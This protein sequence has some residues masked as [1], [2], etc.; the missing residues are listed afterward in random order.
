MV[1]DSRFKLWFSQQLMVDAP[2]IYNFAYYSSSVFCLGGEWG[3][4]KGLAL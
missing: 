3:E 1:S 4:A 2:Q